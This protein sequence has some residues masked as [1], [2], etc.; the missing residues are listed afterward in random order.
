MDER[1]W[2]NGACGCEQREQRTQV[3]TVCGH[4]I[5]WV[6]QRKTGARV[7]YGGGGC[8]WVREAR[9]EEYRRPYSWPSVLL[10]SCPGDSRTPVLLPRRQPYSCTPAPAAAVL[11]YSF[12][13]VL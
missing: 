5:G 13:G 11:L 4:C 10:Y 1:E 6:P 8:V 9:C 3:C 12:P 7:R 2:V